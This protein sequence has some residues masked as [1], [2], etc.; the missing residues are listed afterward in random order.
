MRWTVLSLLLLAAPVA[1][2]DLPDSS[3]RSPSEAVADLRLATAVRLALVA[4]PRTRP[5]EVEVG[6]RDGV[7]RVEGIEDAAYQQVAAGIV[8]AVPGVRAVQGLGSIASTA[9]VPPT[10]PVSIPAAAPRV[11][12]VERG[13]TLFSI[14]RR[15]G[16][17][18]GELRALND[19]RSDAIRVGQRL[20]VR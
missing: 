11:H 16:T 10:A 18:V 2:Q 12:V 15:Y 6:A 1:A 20:A 5:L 14:A 13:D 9:D 17:T 7:V 3:F 4:D 8:R 19:L